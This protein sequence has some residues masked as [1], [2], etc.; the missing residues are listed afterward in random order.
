MMTFEVMTLLMMHHDVMSE[1]KGTFD[2][3][4]E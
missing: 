3:G 4:D 1:R 2:A